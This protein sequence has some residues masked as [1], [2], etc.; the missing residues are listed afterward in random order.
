MAKQAPK[1]ALVMGSLSDKKVMQAAADCL[2]TFSVPYV[3]KVTSAHRDPSTML[4]FAETAAQKGLS[5]IVAAAGGAA[6]L[7]GMIAASTHLP[8]IGVPV[9]SATSLQGWDSILSI[10]QMPAGV[11]VATVSLDGA[12]N[13]ALLAIQ[14]LA[15]EDNKLSL[16]LQK[17][18]K[19]L[20]E[21]VLEQNRTL[22]S[23][24]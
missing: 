5:V 1:V 18:K 16:K 17:Y 6:H 3:W 24:K 11:P 10:L 20:K 9:L 14:I 21:K 7:P 13:A 19:E 12:S 4:H 2:D 22:K 23:E 15:L 8:V